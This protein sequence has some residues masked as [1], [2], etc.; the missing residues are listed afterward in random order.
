M[1]MSANIPI[2][3][4]NPMLYVLMMKD[5]GAWPFRTALEELVCGNVAFFRLLLCIHITKM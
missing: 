5:L 2:M 4:F 3:A 1:P